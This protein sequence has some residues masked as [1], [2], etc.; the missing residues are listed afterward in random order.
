MRFWSS[1]SDLAA[2][3][4]PFA[5]PGVPSLRLCRAPVAEAEVAETGRGPRSR[6][7]PDEAG[8]S[9]GRDEMQKAK[10]HGDAGGPEVAPRR[11]EVPS[12]WRV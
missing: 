7:A 3:P 1:L 11:T 12:L 8:T 5:R 2:H 10:G 9:C 6:S 4:H